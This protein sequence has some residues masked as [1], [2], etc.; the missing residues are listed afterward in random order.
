MTEFHRKPTPH[1]RR[2]GHLEKQTTVSHHGSA[3]R[4]V[5]THRANTHTYTRYTV[6]SDRS[7]E[8]REGMYHDREGAGVGVFPDLLF[9]LVDYGVRGDDECGPR[10]HWLLVQG[11]QEQRAYMSRHT[12]TGW[13]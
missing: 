13:T 12:C 3:A 9:P 11:R 6:E 5:K 10:L 2:L 7:L 8:Y 4:R 1:H